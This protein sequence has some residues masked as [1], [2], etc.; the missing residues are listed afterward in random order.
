MAYAVLFGDKTT[1]DTYIYDSFAI[2]GIAHI[3][4]VSGLHVG[5]LVL[6]ILF[7][8]NALKLNKK[9]QFVLLAILLFWLCLFVRIFGVYS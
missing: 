1:I 5:F 4:A 8:F 2:S 3:L 9:L 7:I 6:I